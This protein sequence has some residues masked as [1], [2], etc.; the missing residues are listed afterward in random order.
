[1]SI[2]AVIFL[3]AFAG[4]VIW[5]TYN[6]RRIRRNILLGR[7][8]DRTDRAGARWALMAKVALGQSKM[9]VRPVV[10]P[11]HVISAG[12]VIINIEALAS[13]STASR[14]ASR[15]ASWVVSTTFR[16]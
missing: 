9:V 3:L 15:C 2:G 12:F 6:V 8:V 10:D 7:D 16:W 11:A 5:F 13:S 14:H 4:A 1:M